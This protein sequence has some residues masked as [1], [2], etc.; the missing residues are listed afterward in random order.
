R[1]GTCGDPPRGRCWTPNPP[2]RC[3]ARSHRR[4][5]SPLLLQH[6]LRRSKKRP[7]LQWRGGLVSKA[8]HSVT[9][10]PAVPRAAHTRW[11][12]SPVR[13]RAAQASC[14]RPR[15]PPPAPR[16]LSPPRHPPGTSPPARSH[17]PAAPSSAPGHRPPASP[18]ASHSPSLLLRQPRDSSS[19]PQTTLFRCDPSVPHPQ[20][21]PQPPPTGDP[22]ENSHLSWDFSSKS[23]LPHQPDVKTRRTLGIFG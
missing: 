13:P 10:P 2:T 11:T 17:H 20:D 7:A 21:G 3:S 1:D 4:N 9:T 23:S 5:R 15:D 18:S 8:Y 22:S 14:S 6:G 16:P 12:P 19:L